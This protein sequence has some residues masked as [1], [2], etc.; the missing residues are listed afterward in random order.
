MRVLD[1][2][3]QE[4]PN[5]DLELG[6]LNVDQLL[7]ARHPA[8]EAVE[9]QGHWETIAVSPNGGKDVKWIVDVV[10]VDAEEAWDEYEDI[11]RYILYTEEELARRKADAEE[12]YRNSPEYRVARL[13]DAL[14]LLLSGVT[15]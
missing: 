15:E 7:K 6:Y 8:V 1:Y 3:D 10:A 4:V 11:Y 9:E 14:E 12:I 5:P 13:D 2:F